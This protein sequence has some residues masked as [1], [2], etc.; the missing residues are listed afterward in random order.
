MDKAATSIINVLAF[1]FK[2][3]NAN[4][5]FIMSSIFWVVDRTFAVK[6]LLHS[7]SFSANPKSTSERVRKGIPKT[8]STLVSVNKKVFLK[9]QTFSKIFWMED[10]ALTIL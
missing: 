7:S 8:T 3:V 10:F 9:N 6:Y 5:F 1:L 4:F 2:A